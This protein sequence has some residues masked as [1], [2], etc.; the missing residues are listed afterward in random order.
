MKLNPRNLPMIDL[1]STGIE[2]TVVDPEDISDYFNKIPVEKDYAP[3][4][5]KLVCF[6]PTVV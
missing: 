6:L 2:D 5:N 3:Y 1:C 4:L